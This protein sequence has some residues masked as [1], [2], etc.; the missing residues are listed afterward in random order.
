MYKQC[1][2][3][4]A[5][6]L[7]LS[8]ACIHE[9]PNLSSF[10]AEAL[11]LDDN[12]IRVLESW[13]LPL[14]I[15]FLSLKRNHIAADGFLDQQHPSLETLNL[16]GN[17]LYVLDESLIEAVPALRKLSVCSAKLNSIRGLQTSQIEVLLLDENAIATLNGLPSTLKILSAQDSEI[18]LIQSRL[19]D[20][21]EY[22]YLSYNCLKYAGLPLRWGNALK[23]LYLS[24]N[25]I[26]QFPRNLPDSLEL[27]DLHSNR[28]TALPTKLP[29]SLRNLN[30]CNNRI[31]TVSQHKRNYSPIQIVNLV[32]NQLTDEQPPSWAVVFRMD[33]N[34]N[35]PKHVLA[36]TMICRAYKR[37]L[38]RN[39]V[40][41]Y[42]RI[43]KLQMELLSISLH[44]D[45]I[46]HSNSFSQE[47]YSLYEPPTPQPQP[48]VC[49]LKGYGLALASVTQ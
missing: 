16:N 24:G 9:L 19:P 8:D 20:T 41:H 5:N 27:L 17:R 39:R 1:F 2:V 42:A 32:N 43:Q 21:L 26:E 7:R 45:R 4:P 31:R 25:E 30:L 3:P 36:Q 37:F 34:W 46:L 6:S 18:S 35:T 15:K 28:I 29:S 22:A 44:P 38:L 11:V 49:G 40:R 13:R 12:D 14:G 10:R 23:E 48:P 47:W 33:N